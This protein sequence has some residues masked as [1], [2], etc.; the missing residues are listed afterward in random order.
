[1]VG[2]IRCRRGR[3]VPLNCKEGARRVF[4]E[5]L[6]E[7]ECWSFGVMRLLNGEGAGPEAGVP[8]EGVL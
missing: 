4:F 3:R 7:M 2:V 1:M 5:N 6:S 8:T